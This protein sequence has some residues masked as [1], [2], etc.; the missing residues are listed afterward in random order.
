L[1]T[2][3]QA[4]IPI[5]YSGIQFEEA[6]RADVMVNNKVILEIKSVETLHNVCKKQLLTYLRLTGI[7]LGFVLNFGETLMKDGIVRI[8]NGLP[9]D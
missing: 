4:V 6:F 5:E 1:T 7:R 2:A 8:V 3:L 9:D